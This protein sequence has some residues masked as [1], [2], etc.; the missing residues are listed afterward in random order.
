MQID[1]TPLPVG[2][3]LNRIIAE[4]VCGLVVIEDTV[5]HT[6]VLYN[7]EEKFCQVPVYWVVHPGLEAIPFK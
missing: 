2:I 6:Y 7:G 1:I 4:K 3:A 5:P